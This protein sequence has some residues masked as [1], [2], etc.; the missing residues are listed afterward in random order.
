MVRVERPVDRLDLVD[1]VH[2]G[3]RDLQVAHGE[4]IR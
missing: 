2:A 3:E 4:R 1:A